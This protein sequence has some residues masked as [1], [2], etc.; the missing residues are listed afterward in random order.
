MKPSIDGPDNSSELRLASLIAAAGDATRLR[1]LS[2]LRASTLSVREIC[3]ALDSAQPRVSHHLAILRRSGLL[4]VE[5]RGRQ[6]FYR[7]PRA[8][9]GSTA[10]ELSRF[11]DRWLEREFVHEK[12]VES[13]LSSPPPRD[14]LEDFLL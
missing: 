11:L 5:V 4:E 10:H 14:E 6:R 8:E 12:A 9:G 7:W 2:L 1:I 3:E 13:R